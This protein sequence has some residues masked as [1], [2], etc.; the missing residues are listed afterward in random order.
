MALIGLISEK[1]LTLSPSAGKAFTQGE[2]VNRSSVDANHIHGIS[3]SLAR[4][5]CIPVMLTVSMGSL[6]RL[7]GPSSLAGL[8]IILLS[9]FYNLLIA[10][11]IARVDKQQNKANDNRMEITTQILQNIKTI[12]FA[13]WATSLE[14]IVSERRAEQLK[15]IRLR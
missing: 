2:I 4:L 1:V 14:T 3:G 12:K 13:G 11:W 9:V 8:V 5:F 6:Y 10:R 7:I 15:L